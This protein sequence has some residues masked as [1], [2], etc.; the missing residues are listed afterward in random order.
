MLWPD[1]NI[2]APIRWEDHVPMSASKFDRRLDP[3]LYWDVET[4]LE[5]TKIGVEWVT[6]ASTTV[7]VE[8]LREIVSVSTGTP[9]W[10]HVMQVIPRHNNSSI[11]HQKII[12]KR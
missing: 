2:P 10:R 3:A 7:P 5:K 8:T 9:F 11:V 6:K 12:G 4:L 1:G